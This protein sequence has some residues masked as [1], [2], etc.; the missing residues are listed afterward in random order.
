MIEPTDEEYY[1]SFPPPTP[2]EEAYYEWQEK[3]TN[4]R[5]MRCSQSTMDDCPANMVL[6]CY[7]C[8]PTIIFED[9]LAV[10]NYVERLGPV[11]NPA[12][13]TQSYV[14]TCGHYVI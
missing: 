6:P 2:E 12:D 1:A 3:H 13:P 11:G 10:K 8:G 7:K 14:L 4:C 5:E 9:E